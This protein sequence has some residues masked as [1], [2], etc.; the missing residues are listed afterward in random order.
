MRLI[1]GR[2]SNVGLYGCTS[3]RGTTDG[4]RLSAY[5]D[6]RS[7]DRWSVVPDMSRYRC[8][9]VPWD[10]KIEWRLRLPSCDGQCCIG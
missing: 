2:A 4:I 8:E 9:P 5:G 6:Y 10:N 1:K 3:G 7:E